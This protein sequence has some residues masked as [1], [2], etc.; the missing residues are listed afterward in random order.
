MVA[1]FRPLL[2]TLFALLLSQHGALADDEQSTRRQLSTVSSEMKKLRQLNQQFKSERNSL[3]AALREAEVAIGQLKQQVRDTN[4]QLRDQQHKLAEL[5][6]QRQQLRQQR[7]Q[8]QHLIEQ[9]VRAAYQL[10]RE[11]KLK[12]LLN[13]QQPQQLSRQLAYYDYFN[14]ARSEQID[15]YLD[16][17]EQLDQ[18][19]PAINQATSELTQSKQ[20]LSDKRKA[21][22]AQNQQRRDNLQQISASLKNNQQRQQQ[23][24]RDR[25]RLEQLLQ[26][27]EESIADLVVPDQQPFKARRGKLPWPA[28]GR[29]SQ[30]FGSLRNDGKQRWQGVILNAREGSAV[31]AVHH[32]RVL[33]ADW[34]RG[35]GL[36]VIIDHG[37]G[38][39][40]LYAHNQ[41]LLVEPGEWVDS[42]A[43]I[44]TVGN[45]GGRRQAGLYF[46]I[47]Y[48]GQPTNPQRWCRRA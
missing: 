5:Q 16:T 42:G 35:S 22:Q 25:R 31:R 43:T 26:A 19:E 2:I 15:A 6:Q 34:F 18:L 9:Q 30:R 17:I 1:V 28:K 44:A 47:R 36:L 3:Q 32:G 27:M 40:T 24:S 11:N 7:M 23:L 48:R 4:R 14:R 41:S 12:L 20:Q 39:M 38:Y 29:L 46:E 37:D 13:Q 45:S 8:Q 10:G 21:L 33:F